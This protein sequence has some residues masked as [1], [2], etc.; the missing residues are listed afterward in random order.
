MA[1]I[2]NKSMKASE[3]LRS[4]CCG[5]CYNTLDGKENVIAMVE[6][7]ERDRLVLEGI[8]LEYLN[9]LE[10]AL[11]SHKITGRAGTFSYQARFDQKEGSIKN[12][13]SQIKERWKL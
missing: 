9:E 6:K 4:E 5:H 13:I 10:S 3:I 12:K 1:D 2:K 7:L 8:V 11:N